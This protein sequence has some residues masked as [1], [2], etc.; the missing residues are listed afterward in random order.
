MVPEASS[1]QAQPLWYR[2][3]LLLAPAFPAASQ[4]ELLALTIGQRNRQVLELRTLLLGRLLRCMARCPQ[5][6]ERLEFELDAGEMV[7]L[8]ATASADGREV[9][10]VNEGRQPM[11]ECDSA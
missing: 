11:R 5:C 9:V 3:W 2:A 6:S 1:G 10:G 7:E 8:A 4:Q